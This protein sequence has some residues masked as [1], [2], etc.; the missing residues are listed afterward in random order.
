M[1]ATASASVAVSSP[2]KPNPPSLA[3][4]SQSSLL[5]I[6]RTRKSSMTTFSVRAS[7]SVGDSGFLFFHPIFLRFVYLLNGLVRF[8]SFD[9]FF[10][11]QFPVVTLLDY[12]AGN[13]RSVRNAI[14]HL[15]F[16][17]KDVIFF[18]FLVVFSP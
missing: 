1:A 6:K 18:F 16:D 3:S 15:G 8:V 9:L 7:S 11:G 4:S 14:R 17:I 10:F 2:L 12:G 5:C 13:V